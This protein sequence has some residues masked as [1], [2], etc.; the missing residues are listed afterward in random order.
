VVSPPLGR[1][2]TDCTGVTLAPGEYCSVQVA[3]APTAAGS[4]DGALDVADDAP[5][6]PHRLAL[7]GFAPAPTPAAA[8]STPAPAVSKVPAVTPTPFAFKA[9]AIV[10]ACYPDGVELGDT[11]HPSALVHARVSAGGSPT[12]VTFIFGPRSGGAPNYAFKSASPLPMSGTDFL[13]MEQSVQALTGLSTTGGG[14][15]FGLEL[16]RDY[17]YTAVA[18]NATGI[19]QGQNCQFHTPASSDGVLPPVFATPKIRLDG[20]TRLVLRNNGD[21]KYLTLSTVVDAA[22]LPPDTALRD[23]QDAQARLCDKLPTIDQQACLVRAYSDPEAK[24]SA[25]RKRPLVL[26]SKLKRNLKAG[27]MTVTLTP[28]RRAVK[29]L[30]KLKPAQLDKLLRSAKLHVTYQPRKGKKVVYDQDVTR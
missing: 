27:T 7:H 4:Y 17:D 19:T 14:K 16:N 6:S 15:W 8:T 30:K 29:A 1:D 18:K 21:A 25:R 28:P 12:D 11:V 26:A 2:A 3:F 5:G 22:V 10:K 23:A 13:W 24:S 9:P 20:T